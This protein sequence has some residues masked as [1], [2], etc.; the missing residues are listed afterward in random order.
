MNDQPQQPMP[1]PPPLTIDDIRASD[2][3]SIIGITDDVLQLQV[4]AI[5]VL[6]DRVGLKFISGRISI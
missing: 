3:A 6:E 1:R 5:N 4:D 2:A